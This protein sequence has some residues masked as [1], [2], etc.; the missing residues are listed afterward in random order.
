[1]V[2]D[3]DVPIWKC[4]ACTNSL[5]ESCLDKWRI[6]SA[7]CP[8]CRDGMACVDRHGLDTFDM[9]GGETQ[10]DKN[11]S[12]WAAVVLLFVIFFM[13]RDTITHAV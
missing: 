4:N 9:I 1:M 2:S 11:V 13:D 8:Y 6:Y 3:D 10:N 7:S 5:H 12:M